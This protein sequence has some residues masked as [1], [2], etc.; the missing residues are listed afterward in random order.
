M[1]LDQFPSLIHPFSTNMTILY[2]IQTIFIILST[3]ALHTKNPI[4][5]NQPHHEKL[6]SQHTHI[7]EMAPTSNERLQNTGN[8]HI[9]IINTMINAQN[10]PSLP[11]IALYKLYFP[12]PPKSSSTA[13]TNKPS[14][15]EEK[16]T[17][18][19]QRHKHLNKKTT[20]I[21]N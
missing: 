13:T 12:D 6:K 14:P 8:F 15:S 20:N 18:K 3:T 4:S 10:P 7:I 9:K 21:Q 19:T 2:L 16:T 5:Y 11:N 17:I 1:A